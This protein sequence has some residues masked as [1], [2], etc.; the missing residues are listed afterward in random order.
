[1]VAGYVKKLEFYF[2]FL[3]GGGGGGLSQEIS[4]IRWTRVKY[5]SSRGGHKIFQRLHMK[6][7]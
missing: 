5:F 1:M 2:P 3:F 4:I 7:H 6:F